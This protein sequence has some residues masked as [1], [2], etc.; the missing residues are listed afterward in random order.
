MPDDDRKN[1]RPL[2]E[3]TV[4]DLRVRLE[5]AVARACPQ[6]FS[7]HRDD[8]VQNALVK[9]VRK[10]EQDR[11]GRNSGFSPMYLMK[12][13]H[14][15]AVDEIRRWC[16]GGK[17]TRTLDDEVL[18]RRPSP[19][20]GPER[21]SVS[22]EIGRAIQECLAGLVGSRQLAVTVYLQGSTAPE[23]SRRLGWTLSKTEKLVYRG[24]S[25]LR[26]CLGEKGIEP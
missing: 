22:R 19:D 25:D 10:M 9:L 11:G 26:R 6:W 5:R 16:R 14:G 23:T 13:A 4:A 1:D 3:D 17:A 20:A 18:E 12:A 7:A 2:P 15:A 24:L 21:S 8:V